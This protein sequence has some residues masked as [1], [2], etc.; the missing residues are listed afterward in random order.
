MPLRGAAR[1][2]GGSWLQRTR[3]ASARRNAA[4]APHWHPNVPSAGEQGKEEVS[5]SCSF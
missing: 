5:T 4:L 2:A 3:A 1:R